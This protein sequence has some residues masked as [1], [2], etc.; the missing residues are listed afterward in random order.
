MSVGMFS[1]SKF[2]LLND[3]LTD[4]NARSKSVFVHMFEQSSIVD[5]DQP[6]RKI[7]RYEEVKAFIEDATKELCAANDERIGQ[8]MAWDSD[9]DGKM[10]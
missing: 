7:M 8:I 3:D 6:D 10:T 4:L 2:P 5:P 1:A 9:A